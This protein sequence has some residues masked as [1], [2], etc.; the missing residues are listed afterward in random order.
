MGTQPHIGALDLGTTGVRFVIF[1]AD[2]TERAS[3]YQEIPLSYPQPG[4]VEQDPEQMIQA[5]LGVL[6]EALQRAGLQAKELAGF[7]ITNQRETIIVWERGSGR[8]LAPAI[9]WQDRRTAARCEQLRTTGWA[10]IIR[11]KTG[12]L[13]DPY[14]SATKIE[15]LIQHLPGLREKMERGQI[16]FGTVDSWLLYRLTGLAATDPSNASRT[17]LF[18]L[19][20]R[21]WDPE[22]CAEFGVVMDSLPEVRPSLSVFACTH[23]QLV[24]AELPVAGLLGDQ[25]AALF[26]Q[27]GFE[28][29]QIKVTW[30]T[31]AFLLLNTGQQPV[32]PPPGLLSTLAYSSQQ[33]AYYALEGSV[34]VA[35]AAVQWLRDNLG[36]IRSAQETEALAETIPDNQGVY[37]VPALA[38]LGAPHW[39]PYARGLLI[40]LT[41]G[42]GRAHL[43]RAAL[44]AIAYQT[45][46]LLRVMEEALRTKIHELRVDGGAAK[47]NLL[48]QFQADILGI[49]VIRPKILETTAL[50]AAF[51]A[52]YAL[53]I[54]PDFHT[55]RSL[56]QEER[57]FLPRMPDSQ[58]QKLLSGWQQ[59]VERARSWAK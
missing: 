55:L 57:R 2:G 10:E 53:G 40:G 59:A 15:W 27:T 43:A 45:H 4:W 38:G 36:I 34:F 24:G 29:G 6:Q 52:G 44:E 49:P 7:G 32:P 33:A 47:N 3:A 18:D 30:G 19:R 31:G 12:L 13:P 23:R 51:A 9:V 17:I 56:W 20:Q 5:S 26:G 46:D 22:L 25:Q 54:W 35:G 11:E 50:G 41:R 48:C 28:A 8:A 14:F 1:Q 16:F 42:T 37:F 39:D 58:R 21:R